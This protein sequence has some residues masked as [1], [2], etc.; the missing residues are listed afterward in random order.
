MYDG[1]YTSGATEKKRMNFED[2][3]KKMENSHSNAFRRG[4]T[5]L[6]FFYCMAR[7]SN[8]RI[9]SKIRDEIK[10]YEKNVRESRSKNVGGGEQ[11]QITKYAKPKFGGYHIRN[12]TNTQ[13]LFLS[14]STT[15]KKYI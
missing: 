8:Q 2:P 14:L 6:F 15:T 11:E 5:R 9:L 10:P 3:K 4:S 1:A 7:W 13:H 12:V